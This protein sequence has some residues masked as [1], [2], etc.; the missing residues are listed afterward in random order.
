MSRTRQWW[1]L[2]SNIR[3]SFEEKGI[4]STVNHSDAMAATRRTPGRRSRS[5]SEYVMQRNC[6]SSFRILWFIT[7]IDSGRLG[8]VWSYQIGAVV[9]EQLS[10]TY[11]LYHGLCLKLIVALGRYTARIDSRMD[12]VKYSVANELL[13]LD[14]EWNECNR[15]K[16]ISSLHSDE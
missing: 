8:L 16:A 9:L 15:L 2:A 4:F 6:T 11:H 3:K 7:I 14:R 12:G 5:L 10:C 1:N 13:C